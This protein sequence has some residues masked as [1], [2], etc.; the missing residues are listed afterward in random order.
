M[1]Q[2]KY[3]KW[4]SCHY[5]VSLDQASQEWINKGFA[6]KFARKYRMYCPRLR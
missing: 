5:Q 4:W 3:I 6:E 2:I 1:R